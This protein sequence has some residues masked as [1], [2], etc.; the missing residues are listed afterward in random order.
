[1][2]ISDV[3]NSL[4]NNKFLYTYTHKRRVSRKFGSKRTVT[5][6][7]TNILNKSWLYRVR[8]LPQKTDNLLTQEIFTYINS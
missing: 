4:I 3:N 2:N 5:N 6:I 1:M 7:Y 8:L